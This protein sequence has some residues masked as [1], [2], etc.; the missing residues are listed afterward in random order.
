ME[1]TRK[2]ESRNLIQTIWNVG[3]LLNNI[4]KGKVYFKLISFKSMEYKKLKQH[5][6]L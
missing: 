4:Y 1:E 5:Y 3:I 2:S 6:K